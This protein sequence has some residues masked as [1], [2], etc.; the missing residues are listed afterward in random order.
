MKRRDLDTTF[1][2]GRTPPAGRGTSGFAT[3][4]SLAALAVA[5]VALGLTLVRGGTTATPTCRSSAWSALPRTDALPAG[6][7]ASGTSFYVDSMAT[8]LLGPA[9][10]DGG[11]E[12]PTV[13]LSVSCYGD[14]ARDALVRSRNAAIAG[15]ATDLAFA[16]L[17]SESFAIR[18][19]S[20]GS[21]SVYV[22]RGDLVANLASAA[23]IDLSALE[24]AARAV[25]TAMTA[26]QSG[27]AAAATP[28][29]VATAGAAAPSGS[30]DPGDSQQL[31]HVIPDLEKVL[32]KR[33]GETDLITES[34]AGSTA[35]GDD[36]ASA[37]LVAALEKIHKK[38]ADLQIAQAYDE[39]RSL[40]L[41]VY[42]FRLPGTKSAVLAPIVID[43]WLAP[44]E[45]GATSSKTAVAGKPMTKVTFGD[46]GA[47]DYVYQHGDIV[48]DIETSDAALAAEIARQLP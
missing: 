34:I 25:D 29:P 2:A 19:A 8:T 24:N 42:A 11:G 26:A 13:Y 46:S 35:I 30:A 17:G 36:A 15:G 31:S 33:A 16:K 21:V 32:P 1:G 27:A 40:E 44:P 4:L 3:V 5:V 48:F 39:A 18:D 7:T 47:V 37:A 9:A 6:W 20:A 43:D 14:A 22:M 38:P 28:A 23:N 10:S 12:A 45:T 41:Y